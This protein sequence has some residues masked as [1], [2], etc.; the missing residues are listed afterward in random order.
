MKNEGSLTDYP[1]EYCMFCDK[2]IVTQGEVLLSDKK[3]IKKATMKYK[4][5]TRSFETIGNKHI[6]K[7]CFSSL[8]TAIYKP[9]LI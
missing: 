3:A 8:R 9:T 6:C 1:A 2:R 7:D 4:Y 5:W